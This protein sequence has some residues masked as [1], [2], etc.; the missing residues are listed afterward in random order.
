MKNHL[1]NK[2]KVSFAYTLVKKH[3]RKVSTFYR[4]KE[5]R[6]EAERAR[7]EEEQKNWDEGLAREERIMELAANH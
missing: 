6:E 7:E 3:F 4:R 5:Q 1:W 2:Y